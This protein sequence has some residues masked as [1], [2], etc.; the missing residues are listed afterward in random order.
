MKLFLFFLAAVLL[1]AWL[2]ATCGH[3]MDR[4]FKARE[5]QIESATDEATADGRWTR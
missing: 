4:R 1:M 2:G 5:I 3:V